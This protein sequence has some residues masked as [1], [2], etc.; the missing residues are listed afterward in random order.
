VTVATVERRDVP[1]ILRATG[2]VEPIQTAQVAA[3]V[4]GILERVTFR[5]GDE[6]Q[7]GQVLFQID[8]RPY[9]AALAQAEAAL[10]RD[11]AMLESAGRDAQRFE[12]LAAKEYVT[13]QQLDQARTSAAS[14]SATLRSD[15]AAV[16]RARLDLDR[17]SVRAP[18]SGRAGSILVRPGNLVRGSSGT[19][20]VVINQITPILVRF[21]VPATDLPAIRR[22][23]G[24]VPAI[25][26]PVGDTTTPQ[27]G[28]LSFVDNAVDSLTGTILLKASFPNTARTLWPGGL[29]RVRLTL[30]TDKGALVVPLGAILTGQQGSSVFVVG[31]SNK[32]KQ[33]MVTVVRSTDSLAILAGGV[34]A[35]AR[36]VT[37]GQV[38]ITDGAI[39]Q[40]V[41]PDSGQGGG[42]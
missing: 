8:P 24:V 14:L 5:E 2:T 4:D 30:S 10:A 31:D 17:A 41:K 25:A 40:V 15:S 18:I 34:E 19:P 22:T 38:R 1:V 28:Q 12:E 9:Q 32:V 20:L 21:P 42:E 23:S 35:G 6:V 29:V 11:L 37:D 3:Q 7:Q 16:M 36:I 33:L 13:A 39:V 27:M 26:L